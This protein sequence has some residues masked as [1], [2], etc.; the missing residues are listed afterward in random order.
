[1][2][3]CYFLKLI[4]YSSAPDSVIFQKH[5][6]TLIVFV[7]CKMICNLMVESVVIWPWQRST[8]CRPWWILHHVQ[9]LKVYFFLR[10]MDFRV[11][12]LQSER[13]LRLPNSFRKK[14]KPANVELELHEYK[15]VGGEKS[16]NSNSTWMNGHV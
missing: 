7:L 4:M 9:T 12:C 11:D 10:L 5:R 6:F 16:R 13:P 14:D 3:L 2:S 8:P 15:T 1:M